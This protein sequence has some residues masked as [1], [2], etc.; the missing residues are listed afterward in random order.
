MKYLKA[1]IKIVL[2]V[3]LVTI[4]LLTALFHVSKDMEFF[5]NK[6]HENN[7]MAETS[8]TEE[9]LMSISERLVEYLYTGEEELLM[10]HYNEREITHMVDVHNLF[11]L[12]TNVRL[13][14]IVLFILSAVFLLRDGLRKFFSTILK[15]LTVFMV[16]IM[17]FGIYIFNNFNSSFTVF[18]ELFFNNDLW[19]LDPETDLMIQ[20]L[21]ENFFMDMAMKIGIYFIVSLL[22]IAV[23]SAVYLVFTREVDGN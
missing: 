16:F 4:I 12:G 3:S 2:I 15:G 19:L 5:R 11:V 17:G 10:P 20:M 8:L 1:P 22:V 9:E 21:P 7:T 18:H 23:V 14:S 13:V 6:F